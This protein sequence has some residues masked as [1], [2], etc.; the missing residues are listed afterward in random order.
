MWQSYEVLEPRLR[1]F[2]DYATSQRS[3]SPRFVQKIVGLADPVK[4][5]QR[6][7]RMK[8][9]LAL[10]D[11]DVTGRTIL[12][13]GCGTGV[14]AILFALNGAERVIGFDMMS[15]NVESLTT[16]LRDFPLPITA[17]VRDI[18]ATRL[19]AASVDGVFCIEAISHFHDWHGF[20]AETG[21]VLRPGGRLLISDWNNGANPR[22]VRETHRLWAESETGPFV[23]DAYANGRNAP[24]LFRRWMLIR[25][26]CPSLTDDEVFKLGLLT[27]GVGGEALRA[28]CRDYL[29]TGR[30]PNHPFVYGTSQRQPENGQANEEPVDPRQIVRRLRDHG[31]TARAL[32]YLG[33]NRHPLLPTLNRMASACAPLA[34]LVTR[35]YVVVGGRAND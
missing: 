34:L 14:N 15:H 6:I 35:K 27:C 12:D 10:A 1:A 5:R 22:L 32:P 3:L 26:E 13:A 20:L 25:R 31:V 9:E 18:A 4:G 28:T 17:E 29:A 11:L 30:V 2:A 33:F 23:A 24:Y 7:R 19:P 21:R 8:Y 16:F